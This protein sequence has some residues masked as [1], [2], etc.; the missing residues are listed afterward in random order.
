[1]ARAAAV[2]GRKSAFYFGFRAEEARDST[3]QQFLP[4][5]LGPARDWLPLKAFA[6]LS[7]ELLPYIT[8]GEKMIC[9]VIRLIDLHFMCQEGQTLC[10]VQLSRALDQIENSELGKNFQKRAGTQGDYFRPK[11]RIRAVNA[12]RSKELNV[13]NCGESMLLL[14]LY[15]F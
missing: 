7:F 4:A 15:A 1:V 2:T 13:R 14:T 3:P 5:S 6:N 9:Y 12:R 11:K 10:F 8:S